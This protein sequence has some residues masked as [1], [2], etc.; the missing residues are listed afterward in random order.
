MIRE[1]CTLGYRVELID[2]LRPRKGF[3]TLVEPKPTAPRNENRSLWRGSDSPAVRRPASAV[4]AT[5]HQL[6]FSA[7]EPLKGHHHCVPGLFF[8]SAGQLTI[9]V[10]DVRGGMALTRKRWPSGVAS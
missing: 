5:A 7:V 10:S 2:P 6:P 4:R 3:S 8:N 9:T 1:L